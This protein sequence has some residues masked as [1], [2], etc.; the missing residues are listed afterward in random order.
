[1]KVLSN[2][3]NK[4]VIYKEHIIPPKGQ[5]LLD[6]KGEVIENFTDNSAEIEKLRNEVKENNTKKSKNDEIRFEEI[7]DE[8]RDFKRSF[9]FDKDSKTLEINL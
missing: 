9:K 7:E 8:L 5:I 2:T 6:D 4:P 3:D 1:M